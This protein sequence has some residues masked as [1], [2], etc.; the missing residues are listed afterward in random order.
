MTKEF[1]IVELGPNIYV[2]AT[3]SIFR[4]S[5]TNDILR[6]KMYQTEERAAIAAK[7]HGGTVVPYVIHPV[8]EE[9][10]EIYILKTA[11][12]QLRSDLAQYESYGEYSEME[13]EVNDSGY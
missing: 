13:A 1:Y 9:T 3:S 11:I 7:Q 12:R 8:G 10:E 2:E 6:A 4:R 5:S